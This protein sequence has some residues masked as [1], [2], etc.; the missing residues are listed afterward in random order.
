LRAGCAKAAERCACFDV[1]NCCR[2]R[3]SII[4]EYRKQ[5]RALAGARL[6]ASLAAGF[7]PPP[8]AHLQ[9][10]GFLERRAIQ[11]RIVTGSH[12]SLEMRSRSIRDR[13][14]PIFDPWLIDRAD[15]AAALREIREL[16]RNERELSVDARGSWDTHQVF[17]NRREI[18]RSRI[19]SRTSACPHM[20]VSQQ[21]PFGGSRMLR[22]RIARA[23]A[24][25]AAPDTTVSSR[26]KYDVGIVAA[27]GFGQVKSENERD[28]SAR[29]SR[30]DGRSWPPGACEGLNLLLF[31][32]PQT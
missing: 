22:D 15:A 29:R 6:S 28:R 10:L 14:P 2:E 11:S 18:G 21:L 4:G 12:T 1:R 13:M 3:L 7:P 30:C 16:G 20:D 25:I 19:L 31:L 8:P 17:I 23:M 24:D 26:S 5:V 9:E 32:H 27:A